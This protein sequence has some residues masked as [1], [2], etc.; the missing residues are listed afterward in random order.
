MLEN[1]QD[2]LN[3]A[4]DNLIQIFNI[5]ELLHC[6]AFIFFLNLGLNTSNETYTSLLT[7]LIEIAISQLATIQNGQDNPFLTMEPASFNNFLKKEN[8]NSNIQNQEQI[9]DYLSYF[10]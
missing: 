4:L 3:H 7:K 6:Q 5:Q 2:L 9:N 1:N 10:L 8:F